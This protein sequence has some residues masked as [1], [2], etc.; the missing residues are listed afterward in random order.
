MLSCTRATLTFLLSSGE[1]SGNKKQNFV[2]ILNNAMKEQTYCCVTVQ[3]QQTAQ[4]DLG[5]VRIKKVLDSD[6]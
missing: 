4:A 3:V 2:R 5:S 1:R 6:S